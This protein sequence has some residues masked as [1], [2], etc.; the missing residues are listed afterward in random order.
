M[1]TKLNIS[2]IG[3]AGHIGLPLSC[4]FQIK[5]HQVK[6]IDK[7]LTALEKASKGIPPFYEKNF[8]ENL[9]SA[10]N[11]GLNYKSDIETIKD[12][13]IVFI[14]LGTSSE[15][16]DI[17]LF[18][19]VL[20]EVISNISKE[21]ILILRSTINHET[22]LKVKNNIIFKE[23][24]LLLAYCPERIA[25]GFAFEELEKMPQI[26][27]VKNSNDFEI[28]SKFFISCG[29]ETIHTTFEEA[30][31]TKLFSN[32]YRYAEFSLINEFSNIAKKHNIDFD[33]IKH[34]STYKYDRLSKLPKTGYVGGPCLPKD[35][36][37]FTHSY[38]VTDDIL[39]KFLRTNDQ[40]LD[41]IVNDC[42]NKFTTKNIIQFGITFKENSDDLRSS[43]AFKLY[44]KLIENNFDVYVVEPNLAIGISDYGFKNYRFEDIKQITDN[45][46]FAVDHKE[47]KLYP[48]DLNNKSIIY[49]HS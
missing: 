2:V 15:D 5:G 21:S 42:I 32:T 36:K 40:F 16:V 25:E 44:E 4:F 29:L 48:T 13:N 27:G 38:P 39:S 12:S 37:T 14:T 23:K 31:F 8:K 24:K 30:V 41:G 49:A 28:V 34:F 47:F 11:L 9:Q 1:P 7:N 43:G 33:K 46:I 35:T 3:G 17:E 45:I 18:D 26:I 6:V 22:I 19:N 10:N 20:E